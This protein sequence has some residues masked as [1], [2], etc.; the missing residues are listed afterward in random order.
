MLANLVCSLIFEKRITTT[1][2]KAKA[3]RQLAEKMVTLAKRGTLAARRRAVSV[4]HQKD[5]VKM[6]F[7][8]IAPQCQDR[9]GGYT[10]IVK[11]ARCR[12][13][14]ATLAIVEWI[15]IRAVDKKKKP[16]AKDEKKNK[17]AATAGA[18]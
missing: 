4:L 3:M 7:A 18:S 1:L 9:N 10:R 17:P 8:D 12:S 16:V 6:L 2:V 11:L 5:V 15:S 14:G 13:D